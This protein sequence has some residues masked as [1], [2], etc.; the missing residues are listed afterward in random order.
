M[1]NTWMQTKYDA[2]NPPA[3]RRL[4]TPSWWRSHRR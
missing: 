2:L 4:I 1:A 3:L